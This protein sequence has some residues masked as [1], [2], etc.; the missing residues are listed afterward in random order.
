MAHQDYT[1]N[2]S[3]QT[4]GLHIYGNTGDGN[5]R[6]EGG[7]QCAYF[8]FNTGINIFSIYHSFS[9]PHIPKLDANYV[10]LAFTESIN[11]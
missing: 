10:A 8:I 3:Y 2:C 5:T 7:A 4:Y 6:N 1:T 9:C 11:I